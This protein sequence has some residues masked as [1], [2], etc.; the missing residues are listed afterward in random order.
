MVAGW[1]DFDLAAVVHEYCSRVYGVYDLAVGAD[2]R[3]DLVNSHCQAF[4]SPF[5]IAQFFEAS[6]AVTQ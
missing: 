3:A 6:K 5:G 4:V 2:V 1:S